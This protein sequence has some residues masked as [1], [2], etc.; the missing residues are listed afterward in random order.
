VPAT[1][2]CLASL[3]NF[4]GPAL[5]A[6]A[7]LPRLWRIDVNWF[8]LSDNLLDPRRTLARA[9]AMLGLPVTLFSG[10]IG[11]CGRA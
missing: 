3:L 11:F 1:D 10:A 4:A 7:S 8:T 5:G 6:S 9:C 2:L